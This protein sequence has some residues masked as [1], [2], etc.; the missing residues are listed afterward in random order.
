VLII[1]TLQG[2]LYNWNTWKKETGLNDS[3][4]RFVKDTLWFNLFGE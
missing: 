2:G 1:F 3:Y 4:I